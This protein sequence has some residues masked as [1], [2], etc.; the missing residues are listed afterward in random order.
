MISK[1]L[2]T[3]AAIAAFALAFALPASA[4]LKV[5]VV[6]LQKALQQTAEIKQAEADLKARFGPRQEQVA[7]LEKEIAKLQQDAEQGQGKYTE[8]AMAE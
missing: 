7:T 5:A 3:L 1:R 2:N 4:Q 8:A 6:D